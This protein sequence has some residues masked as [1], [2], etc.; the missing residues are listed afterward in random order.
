MNAETKDVKVKGRYY[1]ELLFSYDNSANK[2]TEITKTIK[3]ITSKTVNSKEF[4]SNKFNI[5][6]GFSYKNESSAT[7]KFEGEGEGS[8]K[9]EFSLH[10]DSAYELIKTNE[11]NKDVSK[12]EEQESNF[13]IG[14]GDKLAVY[15]L[16][17]ESDGVQQKTF[18]T[19]TEKRNDTVVYLNFRCGKHICGL[20]N[21]LNQF[22]HTDPYWSN[23]EEWGRIRDS[24]VGSSHLTESAAFHQFVQTLSEITPQNENRDEWAAIRGT[25]REILNDW[26]STDK[27]LLLKKLVLRFSTTKPWVTN[28]AEWGEIRRVSEDI[29]GNLKELW[30]VQA[31]AAQV[32]A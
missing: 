21:I 3:W 17:Y 1:W 24:I 13:K 4:L 30:A 29:L 14:A 2:N 11:T 18:T 27:Q 7:L 6:A 8:E 10:V 26:D 31:S 16:C 32:G 23:R 20:G 19:A 12:T 28:K 25:C 9:T 5:N 15:R 22:A